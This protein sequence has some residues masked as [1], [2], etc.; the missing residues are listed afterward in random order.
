[1]VSPRQRLLLGLKAVKQRP[2]ASLR[3]RCLSFLHA[4][5]IFAQQAAEN[6]MLVLHFRTVVE[7]LSR[8][9]GLEKTHGFIKALKIVSK[10]LMLQVD[11]KI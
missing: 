5:S 4:P 1:M 11:G 9:K 10:Y 6:M 3:E 2:G 8:I 7:A